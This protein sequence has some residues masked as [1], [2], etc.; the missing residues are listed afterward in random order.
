MAKSRSTPGRSSRRPPMIPF[1]ARTVRASLTSGNGKQTIDDRLKRLEEVIE[2]L[3]GA[4]DTQF[5]RTAALQAEL[6]ALKG[7]LK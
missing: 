1:T 5:A 2:K 7:S 6:D 4:L 3:Q